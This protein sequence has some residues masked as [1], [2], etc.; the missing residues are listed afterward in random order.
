MLKNQE[1]KEIELSSVPFKFGNK[2]QINNVNGTPKF[3]LILVIRLIY[4]IKEKQ[5]R[6]Q[7]VFLEQILV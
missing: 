7:Q 5:L 4:A 6:T 2:F 1:I 3:G